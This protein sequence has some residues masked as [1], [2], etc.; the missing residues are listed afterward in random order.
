MFKVFLLTLTNLLNLAQIIYG[1]DLHIKLRDAILTKEEI[2]QIKVGLNTQLKFYDDLFGGKV[3]RNLNVK[4]FGKY[5]DYKRY[6]VDSCNFTPPSNAFYS[7]SLD[8]MVI[9]RDPYFISTMFHE[10]SHAIFEGKCPNDLV[11]L[12]EGLAEYFGNLKYTEKGAINE[13]HDY[14][15][16]AILNL[17]TTEDR[18]RNFMKLTNAAWN[19]MDDTYAYGLSWGIVFYLFYHD[20]DAFR[21]IVNGICKGESS[22]EAIENAFPGGFKAFFKNLRKFYLSKR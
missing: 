13:V 12:D 21:K 16:Q 1:Q 17:A 8:E 10:L 22:E 2:Q 14:R 4:I 15:I 3:K 9:Y 11:W 20:T 5:T 19:K 7:P 18:L 6:A